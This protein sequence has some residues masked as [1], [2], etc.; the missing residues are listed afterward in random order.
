MTTFPTQT[1][2]AQR[3]SAVVRSATVDDHER[4]AVSSFMTALFHRELPLAAYTAMVA[5]HHYAYLVLEQAGDALASHPVAGPFVDEALR[6]VPAL[7]ADLSALIGQDWRSHI[8][9]GAATQAYCDRMTQVCVESPERF[10]A[11][12]YTRYMGDLSGGLMIG[13][14]AREAYGLPSGPGA[15]FYEFDQIPDPTSYKEQYRLR[16]DT[17]DWDEDEQAALLDEVRTAYRLNT[18]VFDELDRELG[19]GAFG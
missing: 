13:R 4:A 14:I 16:L 9:P 5:Q 2:E 1:T 11:H 10:V 8:Q 6:R 3:F 19:A 15:S 17:A 18:E 7:E 12:H